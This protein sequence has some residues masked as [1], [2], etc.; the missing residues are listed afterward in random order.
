VTGLDHSKDSCRFVGVANFDS[1]AALTNVS[2]RDDTNIQLCQVRPR[3]D[4]RTLKVTRGTTGAFS[5]TISVFPQVSCVGRVFRQIINVGLREYHLRFL[6]F[7]LHFKLF[8]TC[9]PLIGFLLYTVR[10][11]CVNKPADILNE[12]TVI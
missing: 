1:V 2:Y 4:H 11:A 8:Y 3:K 10:S 9:V 6:S 7:L 12:V 5:Y